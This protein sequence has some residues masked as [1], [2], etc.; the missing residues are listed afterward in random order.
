M[1]EGM[2]ALALMAGVPIILAAL[3]ELIVERSG[4]INIGLEGMMLAAALGAVIAAKG[5]GSAFIGVSGGIAAAALIGAVFVLAAVVLGA[6]QI[7]AGAASNF[8]ALGA[9]GFLYSRWSGWL[10]ADVPTFSPRS[11]AVMLWLAWLGAPALVAAFLWA[12]RP[13]LRLRAAGENPVAL[14]LNGL[15]VRARRFAA[16]GCQALLAGAA[17][18]CVSLGL[19]NGFAENMVAGRGFIALAI[20]IFGRWT[21]KGLVAGAAL[22]SLSIAL[23]YAVQATGSGLP[24]HLLLA[25]PYVVTLLVLAFSKAAGSAPAALG[26]A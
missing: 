20:V 7:V 15:S 1:N 14:R 2:V 25:V 26:R 5:S 10:V 16:V 11:S 9:T 12:T 17:G 4:M 24:F 6:D 18:A 23:Q 3:G 22:F 19:A 13:G 21:V 8:I